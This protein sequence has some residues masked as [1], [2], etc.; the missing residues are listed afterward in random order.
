MS[1]KGREGEGLGAESIHQQGRG[2]PGG[3]R[4][5]A[6]TLTPTCACAYV[7]LV[8]LGYD[9]RREICPRPAAR[10]VFWWTTLMGAC[11]RGSGAG[12]RQGTQTS[13]F[14]PT[15]DAQTCSSSDLSVQSLAR[16]FEVT[17]TQPNRL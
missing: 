9:L 4:A 3:A 15:S 10:E 11:A 8:K 1:T 17:P 12:R 7:L 2:R 5:H 16:P 6:L 14:P 13:S